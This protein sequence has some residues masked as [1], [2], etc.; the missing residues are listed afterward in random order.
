LECWKAS[1]LVQL[2]TRHVPLQAH[3]CRIGK[4]EFPACPKCNKVD[5]LFI[6]KLLIVC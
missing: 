2:R 6:F 1:L 3:L 4:A 5:L